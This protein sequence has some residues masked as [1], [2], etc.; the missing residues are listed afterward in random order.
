MPK[1][2]QIAALSTAQSSLA[3]LL[4]RALNR[5]DFP[6]IIAAAGGTSMMR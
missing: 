4:F 6:A 1:R 2:S 3:R 5:D